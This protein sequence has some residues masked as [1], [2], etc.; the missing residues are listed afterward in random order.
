MSL[1]GESLE[2]HHGLYGGL[3]YEV[4]VFQKVTAPTDDCGIVEASPIP[5]LSVALERKIEVPDTFDLPEDVVALAP[6]EYP[7]L[8]D[9]FDENVAPGLRHVRRSKAGGWPT[10][11][12]S[13]DWPICANGSPATFVGQIDWA[14]G[15]EASWC[16][17]GYAYLFA[18][19]TMA[20]PV[21]ELLIQ[22]T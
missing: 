17:G 11:V 15:E 8:R 1:G 4:R 13:N 20:I 5:P 7:Y 9:D 16:S 6:I 12:Q 14:V 22:T 19:L 10:W 21:G 18:D 3:G 2:R